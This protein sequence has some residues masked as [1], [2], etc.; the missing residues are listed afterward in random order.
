MWPVAAHPLRLEDLAGPAR[1]DVITKVSSPN[2]VTSPISG[3]QAAFVQVEAL[4]QGPLGPHSLGAVIL[5]DL[6]TLELEG[7]A[8]AIE[9]AVRRATLHFLDERSDA[10]PMQRAIPELV[11]FFERARF[12]GVLCQ[13]EY[14]VLSGDRLR[15]RAVVERKGER[16]MVR[17]DLAPVLLDE[18][19]EI[20]RF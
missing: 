12:G 1:V 8:V 18:V 9:L 11:P 14:L 10:V 17:D 19:I 7:G 3:S 13:R 4:Q 2:K 5:G 6:V 16:L 20:P 15:L